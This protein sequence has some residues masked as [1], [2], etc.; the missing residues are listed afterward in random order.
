MGPH[1]RAQPRRELRPT[2]VCAT[3]AAGRRSPRCRGRTRRSSRRSR[4]GSGWPPATAARP[5]PGGRTRAGTRPR[6]AFRPR[7]R[8]RRSVQRPAAARDVDP[9]PVVAGLQIE[10]PGAVLRHG[11]HLPLGM[12]PGGLLRVDV[13]PR[14]E[15]DV[16]PAVARRHRRARSRH[17]RPRRQHY[18]KRK[19]SRPRSHRVDPTR[20]RRAP[21]APPIRGFPDASAA[22]CWQTRYVSVATASGV[23][24]VSGNRLTALG[25]LSAGCR[26]FA[27]Y[28]ITPSSEIFRTMRRSCRGAAGWASPHPR[29]LG[30]HGVRRRVPRR[31]PGDD[32]DLGPRLLPDDRDRPVRRHD[33]DAGRDRLRPAARPLYGR[34]DAGGAGRRPARRVLHVGGDNDPGLRPGGRPGLLRADPR[35]LRLVGAP[36]H[37]GRPALGQGGRDDARGRRPPLPA[38]GPG[39]AAASRL[40]GYRPVRSLCPLL[41]PS[42]PPSPPWGAACASSPPG[43]PTTRRAACARARPRSWTCFPPSRRRSTP[44]P[45]SSR[46]SHGPGGRR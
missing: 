23:E 44:T 20:R 41:P 14:A 10:R 13:E 35:R 4:C 3:V 18:C 31:L 5:A 25:A 12:T 8:H 46:S 11:R 40:P 24:L 42:R 16:C 29:D 1:R 45:T 39:Q 28:P 37:A 36:A 7:G 38:G 43:P 26:F 22:P 19:A 30:A 2:P 15:P 33:R 32:G 27:G 17:R 6:P 34:R 21:A 9:L